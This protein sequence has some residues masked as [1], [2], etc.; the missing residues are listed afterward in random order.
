MRLIGERSLLQGG[1][2]QCHDFGRSFEGRA[3]RSWPML[4][5]ASQ[6]PVAGGVPA[7]RNHP[8]RFETRPAWVR[9]GALAASILLAM[10]A[11]STST[12]ALTA[13]PSPSMTTDAPASTG[14]LVVDEV[15]FDPRAG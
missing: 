11:A 1:K 2:S 14:G 12:T 10:A 15:L 7:G 6:T 13:G 9:P 5:M 4:P 3:R 8:M